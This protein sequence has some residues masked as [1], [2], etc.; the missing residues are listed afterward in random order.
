VLVI[1]KWIWNIGG[2][3][4]TGENRGNVKENVPQC[5][6]SHNKFH[7]YWSA[8]EP[9]LPPA[10]NPPGHDMKNNILVG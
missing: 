9:G 5:H 3:S 8:I 10:T 4:L 7:L 2:A 6:F 1:S